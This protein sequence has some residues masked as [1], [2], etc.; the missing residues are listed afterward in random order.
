MP[1]DQSL[2]EQRRAAGLALRTQGTLVVASDG[3]DESLGALIVAQELAIRFGYTP[4]LVSVLEPTDVLIPPLRSEPPPL[5]RGATR[6]QDRRERLRLLC[7]RALHDQARLTTRMLI[8]DVATTIATAATCHRAQLVLT[9]RVAHRRIERAIRREMPLAVARVGPV[10]VLS[11]PSASST[12]PRI[13]VV[14]VG[15]GHAASRLGPVARALFQDA[16]A[17]HLVS[18]EPH[19]PAPWEKEARADENELTHHAQRAFADVMASWKLPADIPIETH[20]LTGD[21]SSALL[22]FVTNVGADLLV[23]GAAQRRHGVHLPG[24]DLATKLYRAATCSILLIPVQTH[25]TTPRGA[26]TSV[27]LAASEWPTLLGDFAM[28]NR[29]RR[30]SLIVDEHG[31]PPQSVVQDWTLSG[32]HCDRGAGTIA[33][34]LADPGDPQR[35]V[36]H[37]VAQPT[38]LA[39][40]GESSGCDDLL[41]VGYADGQLT[42]SLS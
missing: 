30:A 36:S 21:E 2:A 25:A 35:H 41:V 3:S 38:V 8:G 22:S 18:V 40:Q 1:S 15:N 5:H 32:V 23:V 19:V 33:I 42:L 9:G 29:G 17:V 26:A 28:R 14:A 34:M 12:L 24:T 7:K 6:L 39:L 4:E 20:I 11:V 10:P 27:S 37:V 13:V 31:G 16:V